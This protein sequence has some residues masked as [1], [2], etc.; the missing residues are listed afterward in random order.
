MQEGSAAARPGIPLRSESPHCVDGEG[1]LGFWRIPGLY[2]PLGKTH[3]RDYLQ[4]KLGGLNHLPCLPNPP[5][6]ESDWQ[7]AQRG[8]IPGQLVNPRGLPVTMM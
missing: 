5:G 4:R 1:L 2:V 7:L 3:R 8:L 6:N